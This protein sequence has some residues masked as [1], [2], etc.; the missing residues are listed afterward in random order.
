M[1]RYSLFFLLFFFTG[2]IPDAKKII[3]KDIDNSDVEM[4]WYFHS[5]ITNLSADFV[6]ISKGDSTI[7]IYKAVNTIADVLIRNDSII[8]K[9]YFPSNGI[10]YTKNILD[11]VFSYKIIIDTTATENEYLNRPD[12][13]LQ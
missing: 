5:Y 6:D 1:I 8:I 7:I 13:I 12:G 11:E 9:T 10:I 2:C 3:R 4:T